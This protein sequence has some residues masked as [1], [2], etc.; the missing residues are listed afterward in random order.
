MSVGRTCAEDGTKYDIIGD[1]SESSDEDASNSDNY[2][3]S[4]EIW[5]KHS[6]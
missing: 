3:E 5:S 2:S 6:A 1:N 4:E